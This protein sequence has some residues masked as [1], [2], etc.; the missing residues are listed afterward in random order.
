MKV[1]FKNPS[2]AKTL[3]RPAPSTPPQLANSHIAAGYRSARVGG[4]FYD[5]T[6]VGESRLAFLLLDIAGQRD[7]ALDIAA[8]VQEMF[9]ARIPEIFSQPDVNEADAASEVLVDLNRKIL[10]AAGGVRCAP[11]FLGLYDDTLGILFYINAGHT[12]ALLRDQ[13]GITQLPAQ[14]PPLGLFS[15]TTSDAQMSVLQPGSALLLVS[16]GLIEARVRSHEYGFG[17]LEKTFAGATITDAASLC[18]TVLDDVSEFLVGSSGSF[19]VPFTRQ[20]SAENPHNDHTALALVR[21][22]RR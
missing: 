9:R 5:F 15:H 7:E 17:R 21:G 11:A 8:H 20:D 19:H 3:A 6:L 13:D 4:D 1:P 22:P 14:G 12:A 18:R 10:E 2:P 16:K